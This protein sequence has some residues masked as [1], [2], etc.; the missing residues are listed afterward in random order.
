M[1]LSELVYSVGVFFFILLDSFEGFVSL[2]LVLLFCSYGTIC[3]RFKY[4]MYITN[5]DKFLV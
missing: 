5:W 4:D 1:P 3:L 2:T